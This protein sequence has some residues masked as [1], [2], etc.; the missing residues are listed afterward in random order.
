MNSKI[1]GVIAAAIIIAVIVT[2]FAFQQDNDIVAQLRG[3]ADDG[4]DF[5]VETGRI[6]FE[7]DDGS[8]VENSIGG[9]LVFYTAP[10]VGAGT[11]AGRPTT[12]F[13]AATT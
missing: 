5:T 8:P 9:A 3:F 1:I 6:Q 4:V 7:V 12:R 13:C 10:G 11:A 2:V